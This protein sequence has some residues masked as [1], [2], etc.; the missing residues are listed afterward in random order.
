MK[1]IRNR[2]LAKTWQKKRKRSFSFGSFR[3]SFF[4]K[5]PKKKILLSVFAIAITCSLI[6]LFLFSKT[7]EIKTI[8]TKGNSSLS[9]EE[10]EGAAKEILS[11]KSY[12]YIL[13]NNFFILNNEEIESR[14]SGKFTEIDSIE[15][16]KILPDK[17]EIDIKEKNPALIWCRNECYFVNEEGIAF[18]PANEEELINSDKHFIKITEEVEIAE[19]TEEEK[20]TMTEADNTDIVQ[21]EN[22]EDA[23]KSNN[24]N[25]STDGNKPAVLSESVSNTVLPPIA[26]NEAVS[27]NRFIAFA[28]DINNKIS[29]N[30]KLKIKYYK[31]KGTKTREL[32]AFTDQNTKLYFDTTKSAEKQ[33]KNL[34]YLLDQGLK[35][36]QVDN[37]QYIYLKN[38]DR[39]F[40]K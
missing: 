26:F 32:I 6:Y 29:H 18:A 19:E 33:A 8:T 3:V 40:Y 24:S 28:I 7:F 17:I 35:D 25:A 30:T 22:S 4:K 1:R 2:K 16:K 37:I 39:V 23:D 27:D 31:T 15:V 38:E 36:K 5:A 12:N 10:I 14:L 20:Q 21:E 13:K 9:N 11:E 34:S